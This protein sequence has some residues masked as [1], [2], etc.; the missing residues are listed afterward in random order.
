MADCGWSVTSASL[1]ASV[2]TRATTLAETRQSESPTDSSPRQTSGS[3]SVTGR[4]RSPFGSGSVDSRAWR[5]R[6]ASAGPTVA[7]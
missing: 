5:M 2:P 1:R 3:S 4:P 6:Y 7:T